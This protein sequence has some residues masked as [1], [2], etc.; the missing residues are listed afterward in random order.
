MFWDTIKKTFRLKT[1]K[2][3]Y[4]LLLLFFY[5]CYKI[6]ESGWVVALLIL[7]GSKGENGG[8]L[9]YT[10][11]VS[12]SWQLVILFNMLS[13]T[14]GSLSVDLLEDGHIIQVHLLRIADKDQ[15]M[16]VTAK[17]ERLLIKAL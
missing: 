6:I 11:M 2:R 5:F 17:I 8:M 13:M 1:V 9:E 12:K 4:Y 15:F 16:A 14:P 3:L 7:K 10:T